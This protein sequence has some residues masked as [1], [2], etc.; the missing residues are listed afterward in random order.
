MKKYISVLPAI[1]LS[2]CLGFFTGC[3][4]EPTLD[5]SKVVYITIDPMNITLSARDTIPMVAHVQN[6]QGDTIRTPLEWSSDD[7]DIVY[8]HEN[9]LIAKDDAQGKSTKIRVSLQ[10]G[11]YA[12]TNATVVNRSSMKLVAEVETQES[13]SKNNDSL[14]FCVT[15]KEVLL[16]YKP[17]ITNPNPELVIPASDEPCFIDF[18]TGRFAYIFNTTRSSGKVA[19]TAAIGPTGNSA[20]ATST[21]IVTPSITSSLTEDFTNV[22]YELSRTMDVNSTDTVWVYTKVDPTYDTDL[23]NAAQLY[24]WTSEGN[25]AQMYTTGNYVKNNIGHLAYAVVRSGQFTGQSKVVFECNGTVLTTT[26]DVQDY[27]SQ[28]PVDDLTV[29]KPSLKML[30]QEKTYIIPTVTPAS[31]FGFHVP[32]FVSMDESIVKVIGYNNNE[33]MIQAVGVGNTQLKV[34]S[35]DKVVYVDV[36]VDIKVSSILID[37]GLQ[38]TLFEGQSTVWTAKVD[39]GEGNEILP[40]WNSSNSNIASIDDKGVVQAH[41]PGQTEI[42]AYVGP[43]KSEP[44]RMTVVEFPTQNMTYTE[45]DEP[46]SMYVESNATKDIMLKLEPKG[47]SKPVS[48]RIIPSTPMND[49]ENG[50]YQVGDGY[51]FRFE[52]DEAYTQISTGELNISNYPGDKWMRYINGELKVVSGDKSFIIKLDNLAVYL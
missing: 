1:L 26:V 33:M 25:G 39:A 5:N 10:N 18:E 2:S 50:S 32:K 14:W 20:K 42:Y 7:E 6:L 23:N 15:P 44:V 30:Y 40:F 22:T 36:E 46:G 3:S 52:I 19:I 35:N 13:Y 9:K 43:I 47:G 12:I 38:R 27:A 37:Q 34:T 4:D 48:I 24:N 31:S 49:I 21:V 51:Q 41:Y 8:F 45:N 29:D 28:Y 17:V 16:D 11:R